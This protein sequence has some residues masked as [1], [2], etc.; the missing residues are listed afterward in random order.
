MILVLRPMPLALP[1]STPNKT[2]NAMPKSVR[3]RTVTTP[4]IIAA[5]AMTAKMVPMRTA[6]SLVPN[7]RMAH[8]L[9]PLGT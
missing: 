5:I 9:R 4:T 6:L 8:S 1:P 3:P 2:A 7:D